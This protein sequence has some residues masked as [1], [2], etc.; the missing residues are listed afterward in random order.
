M[1][2]MIDVRGLYINNDENDGTFRRASR[3]EYTYLIPRQF[4]DM[5]IAVIGSGVAG[6]APT[7]VRF[8]RLS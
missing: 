3:G 4:H 2:V 1:H 7:W 8:L 5:R 6:L